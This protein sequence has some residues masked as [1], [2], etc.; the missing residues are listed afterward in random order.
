[1]SETS[2][3]CLVRGLTSVEL[4]L[5]LFI[6]VRVMCG[7]TYKVEHARTR[8]ALPPY[9]SVSPNPPHRFQNGKLY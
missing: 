5:S 8:E 4:S 9:H 1:M 3:S 2:V 6:V 7:T